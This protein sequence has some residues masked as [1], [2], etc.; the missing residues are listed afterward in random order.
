MKLPS[1]PHG[2]AG[3]YALDAVTGTEQDNFERHLDTCQ[4]CTQDVRGL[5]EIASELALAAAAPPP[6][7]LRARVLAALPS[8]EQLPARSDLASRPSAPV[9]APESARRPARPRPAH[10]R[11]AHQLP[12]RRRTGGLPRLAYG[13]AA[14]ATAVAVVLGLRLISVEDQLSVSRAEQQALT[15]LLNTPG[16]QVVVKTTSRGGQATAVAVPGLQKVV[17]LTKGLPPLLAGKVYQVWL[18][19]VKSVGIRS[20]GLLPPEPAGGSTTL[21][22][23]G[24]VKGDVVG[25][26]VEPA[27]GSPQPT[28]TPIVLIPLKQ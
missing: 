15:Q 11:P 8:V 14:V 20:A 5:H 4:R 2:L 27:G 3:V 16:V 1:S 26:T 12:R 23:S 19:G 9:V 28:T 6:P 17:V 7:Q 25:I 22:A 13:L 21:L 10:R 18:I 24:V